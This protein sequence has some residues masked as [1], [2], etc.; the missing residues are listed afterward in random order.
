[1]LFC[2]LWCNVETSCHRTFRHPFLASTNTAAYYQKAWQ[3][4]QLC[5]PCRIWLCRQCVPALKLT[6]LRQLIGEHVTNIYE[7]HL[8]HEPPLITNRADSQTMPLA[9]LKMT[10]CMT[11]IGETGK[12]FGVRLQ[13]HRTEVE[14]KTGR[15]FTRSLR[16]S[17]LT[18]HNK[19]ALTDRPRNSREP[20][21]QLVSS[22]GDR[23]RARAFY[24][25]NQRVHTLPK[26]RTTGHEP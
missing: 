16:A 4:R 8:D 19:S 24:Q 10:F 3:S 12:E 20:C 14:S 21:H 15:T 7:T 18:E 26:G 1:M 11:D 17:S 9:A 13:E 5:Q 6:T 23:Q 2:C 22:D 25:M